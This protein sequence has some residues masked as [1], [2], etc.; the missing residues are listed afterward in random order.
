MARILVVDDEQ[1]IR[2]LLD[3]I[4]RRRGHDVL[5]ADHGQKALELF[6]R[7]RP[8]VVILDL[9]MPGM[10]GIAAL[11]QLRTIDAQ[12]PVIILTG[13]GTEA[14]EQQARTLGVTDFL[15]KGFSLHALGSALDRALKQANP[16]TS[17]SPSVAPSTAKR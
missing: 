16:A 3:T 11:K 7:E 10:N 1:S 15:Q 4:L 8:H 17:S 2:D 6:Q 12:T 9:H 14:M 5:L 13:V